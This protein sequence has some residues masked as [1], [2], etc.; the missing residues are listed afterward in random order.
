MIAKIVN[1]FILG[2]ALVLMFDFL[3]FIGLKLHYFD[4]HNIVEY[5]NIYFFDNQPYWLLATSALVFGVTMLYTRFT[6]RVQMIYLVVLGLSA[7]TLF[8]PIGKAAGEQF[9]R[10]ENQQ[11]RVGSIRFRADLLYEGRHAL[12]LKRDDIDHTI[13]ILKKDVIWEQLAGS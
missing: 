7:L 2:L 10:V 3:I 4:A 12:Y 13:R 1:G 8:E 9:F 11:F 6:K 5:F